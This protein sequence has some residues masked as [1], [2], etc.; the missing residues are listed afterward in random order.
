LVFDS[1]G[2][3]GVLPTTLRLSIS[4]KV[5]YALLGACSAT[6]NPS[7]LTL[8]FPTKLLSLTTATTCVSRT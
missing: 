2:A 3:L 4:K 5:T 7:G 8:A 6:S 1:E